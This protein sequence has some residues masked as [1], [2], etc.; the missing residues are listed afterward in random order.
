MAKLVCVAAMSALFGALAGAACGIKADEVSSA[1]VAEA[2][3][4]PVDLTP[5]V[6]TQA[7]PAYS[8]W[9]RLAQCE[10][11]GNWHAATGNGYSGGL[12]FD[13]ST[14]R[15]YGG[16]ALAPA[17][18]LATRAQQIVIAERTLAA[19]GWAAWPACSRRLGLR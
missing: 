7:E 6:V 8:V 14:W 2:A 9:D 1:G 15:R 10:A 17:A 4:A 11:T 5:A 18:Y 16:L 19:Q 3:P 12:Q 13:A